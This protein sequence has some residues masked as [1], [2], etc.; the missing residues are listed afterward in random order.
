MSTPLPPP[1]TTMPLCCFNGCP[2]LA[3]PDHIDGKCEVHKHKGKCR[4]P[5]CGNQVYARHLCV[6][7]GAKRRCQVPDCWANARRGN[8][9]SRHGVPAFRKSCIEEGCSK[10]AQRNQRCVAHG[11]GRRCKANDC[12]RCARS[13]GY[14]ARHGRELI[15]QTSLLASTDHMDPV[16]ISTRPLDVDDDEAKD[17]EVEPIH[18][19][20]EVD[21]VVLG[22][23]LR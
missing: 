12:T 5:M 21:A 9:C 22:Y 23:F 1:G 7:H 8:Y 14:C 20:M 11:G 17:V 10:H 3:L 16:V 13:G 19:F 15:Q 2:N 18:D 4:A 6:R